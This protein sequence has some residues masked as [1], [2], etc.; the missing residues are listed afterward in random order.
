MLGRYEWKR[1]L[2]SLRNGAGR[3]STNLNK[4]NNSKTMKLDPMLA[5]FGLGGS[6]LILILGVAL[7]LFGGKKLPEL[8]KGLGQGIKEFKKAT[9][10]ASEEIRHSLEDALPAASRCLP[11]AP[12]DT[13]SIVPQN[14]RG[15]KV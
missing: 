13:E 8:A 3:Q 9:G 6:E 2:E 14:L 12:A 4:I 7:L 15:P 1:R 5:V 11:Q 10:N